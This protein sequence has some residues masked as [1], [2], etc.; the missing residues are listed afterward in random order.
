MSPLSKFSPFAERD[1][2]IPDGRPALTISTSL[3]THL[4]RSIS[5]VPGRRHEDFSGRHLTFDPVYIYKKSRPM[6][7]LFP[8]SRIDSQY[9]VW[10]RNKGP[11][12]VH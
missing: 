10:R 11:E 9:G 3:A 2:K 12:G 4:Q 7:H 5:L 6:L 1:Q 8:H